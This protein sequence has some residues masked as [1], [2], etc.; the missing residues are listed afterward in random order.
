MLKSIEMINSGMSYSDVE[1]LWTVEKHTKPIELKTFGL[2]DVQ[3]F[4]PHNLSQLTA[5][6]TLPDQ[7]TE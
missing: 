5:Y 1:K 6:Y 3:E 2:D 4:N 7:K